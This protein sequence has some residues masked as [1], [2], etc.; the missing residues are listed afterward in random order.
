MYISRRRHKTYHNFSTRN[1]V[2]RTIAR[3]VTFVSCRNQYLGILDHKGA[4]VFEVTLVQPQA[5]AV[6]AH[7]PKHLQGNLQEPDVVD[8]PRQLHKQ[9]NK[10]RKLAL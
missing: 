6:E 8:W 5:R 4:L 9:Q 3:G 10:T 7:A 1:D 2:A